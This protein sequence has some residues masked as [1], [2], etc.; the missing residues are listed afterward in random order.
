MSTSMFLRALAM[1][2]FAAAI[3]VAPAGAAPQ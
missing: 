2:A 3:L 1:P